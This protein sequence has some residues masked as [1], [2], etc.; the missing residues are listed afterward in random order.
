M[1]GRIVKVRNMQ[2]ARY[3]NSFAKA[4]KNTKDDALAALAFAEGA[5]ASLANLENLPGGGPAGLPG[6][7]PGG[8][9]LQPNEYQFSN[10]SNAELSGKYLAEFCALGQVEHDFLEQAANALGLSARSCTRIL[11]ISR[12]IADLAGDEM[13]GVEHLAEAVNFRFLDRPL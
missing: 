3:Q 11:R 9:A 8:E 4:A 13:I 2:A 12:T 7:G 1:R 5:S 6:G 10:M